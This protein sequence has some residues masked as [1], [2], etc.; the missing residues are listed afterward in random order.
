MLTTG[1]LAARADF[2]LGTAIVQ[3]STRTVSGPGGSI[4]VE[5]R[6]MQVLVTLADSARA[7]VTRETLFA[8]CWG[9]VFVG[10]DSLNRAIAGV[11]RI[12]EGVAAASFQIETVPRTGYRLIGDVETVAPE[13]GAARHD[14]QTPAGWVS[15]RRA[16]GGALAAATVG[17]FAIWRSGID[18]PDPA[19]S[20]IDESRVAM[21]SSTSE[22]QRKAIT[23]LEQAVGRTPDSAAAWGM[24]ALTRARVDEHAIGRT[25]S[26]VEVE[27]AARRALQ[28]D[29]G[30]ADAKAALAV[31]VPYYGDWLSAE[32]R[33]DKVLAE[34]PGHLFTMDS[35]AF[36]LGAV[37]RMQE[38]ARDRLAFAPSDGLDADLHNR[39][40]YANW[41]LGRIPEADQAAQ[42]G[43]AMWPKH[44][45][46]WFGRLW[47]LTGTERLDRALAHVDDEAQR[48][49]LPPPMIATLR[50]AINAAKSGK[51]A[52]VEQA[53]RR[54]LA[55]VGRS[56]AA[57]V[58]GMMLLNLMKAHDQAFALARAYYLEQGPII[59]AMDWRPGQ[60][61][62]PDQ[63][64]RKTNMLF[65]PLAATMQQDPR[66]LPLMAEMGLSEYWKR[67]GVVPDFLSAA[68]R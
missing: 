61:F 46:L 64:R 4:Q 17:G 14:P 11:R 23:L 43:L 32:R 40:V 52:E 25:V 16:M 12:A 41:F 1:A 50:G 44:A 18:S 51:T 28:L 49:A 59:A 26:A 3:P 13:A 2:K 68:R 54:V 42:R 29:P 21:R 34:H 37:G 63:R 67:R 24:L 8:R 53:S 10:D 15:R 55:G 20:L 35:R 5:P 45:G 27:E 31:A 36:L 66:F 38:S 65:T 30:N 47:V 6:V 62:L 48:P 19:A 9:G 57:V 58:N 60:P 56:V 7:V 33:F 39:S 22:G